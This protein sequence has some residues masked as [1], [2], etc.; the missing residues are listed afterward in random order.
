V[1]L[2]VDGGSANP[3]VLTISNTGTCGTLASGT[4][5]SLGSGGYVPGTGS[6]DVTFGGSSLAYDGTNHTLTIT[7]GSTVGGNGTSTAVTSSALTLTLGITDT[8]GNTV[9]GSP[10]TSANVQQF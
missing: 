10:F 7:F 8:N 6:K 1:T 2:R 9:S 4:Q 5:I 3:N